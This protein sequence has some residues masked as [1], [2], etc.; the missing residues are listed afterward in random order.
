[1]EG[2]EKQLEELEGLEKQLEELEGL[3]G[4]EELEGL[5][6]SRSE[7]NRRERPA[8]VDELGLR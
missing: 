2:L 7:E 4:L 6:R 8:R 1:M 3:E 5:A